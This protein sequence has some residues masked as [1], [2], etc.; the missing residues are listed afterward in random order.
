[1]KPEISRLTSRLLPTFP[2]LSWPDRPRE[3]SALA[4]PAC[5]GRAGRPHLRITRSP[6]RFA[7]GTSEVRRAKQ[8]GSSKLLDG[9]HRQLHP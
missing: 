4:C 3:G 1:M 9:G 7:S 6:L 5:A 8:T 2:R